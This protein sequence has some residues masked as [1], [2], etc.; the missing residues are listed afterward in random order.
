[1]SPWKEV[2]NYTTSNINSTLNSSTHITKPATEN[3]PCD[4]HW[5]KVEQ[6]DRSRNRVNSCPE[7][8]RARQGSLQSPKYPETGPGCPGR[9]LRPS[10]ERHRPCCVPNRPHQPLRARLDPALHCQKASHARKESCQLIFRRVRTG[11][12][13]A[14]WDV[15]STATIYGW[16]FFFFHQSLFTL[17]VKSG[18][19]F[20][21]SYTKRN[22][23]NHY[24]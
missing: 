1:M 4:V 12:Y 23:L 18:F 24:F 2:I 14:A 15:T 3:C 8:I 6:G 13:L 9:L 22:V 5:I 11:N 20:R 17:Y 16:F 10:P 7:Y 21:E 19:V